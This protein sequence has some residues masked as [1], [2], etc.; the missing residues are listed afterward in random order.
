M[1]LL[2]SSQKLTASTEMDR[3]GQWNIGEQADPAGRRKCSKSIQKPVL[4]LNQTAAVRQRHAPFKPQMGARPKPKS[5]DD[6]SLL[7]LGSLHQPRIPAA[8]LS[9]P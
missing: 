8:I 9:T 2:Q 6:V 5:P 3:V 1:L 4:C 7:H